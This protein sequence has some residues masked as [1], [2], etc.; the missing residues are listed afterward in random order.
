ME[1]RA[2]TGLTLESD[3]DGLS[4]RLQKAIETYRKELRLAKKT[5][6]PLPGPAADELKDVQEDPQ[7]AAEMFELANLLQSKWERPATTLSLTFSKLLSSIQQYGP[8]V[9]TVIRLAP[10]PVGPIVWGSVKFALQVRA[11]ESRILINANYWQVGTTWLE[12]MEAIA[13]TFKD[14]K[15]WLPLANIYQPLAEAEP[16]LKK[17]LVSF[18]VSLVEFCTLVVQRRPQRGLSERCF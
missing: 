11:L 7:N 14:L 3:P 1:C 2:T 9:D 5:F 15:L 6:N 12:G 13:D 18:Q 17:A 4:S 8:V 10:V 16:E